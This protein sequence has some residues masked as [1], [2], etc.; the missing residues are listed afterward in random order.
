[1]ALDFT[2]QIIDLSED[3]PRIY[4][5]IPT[6]FD[7]S[8]KTTVED[9]IKN[10]K[11]PNRLT[12][13]LSVQ[14]VPDIDFSDIPNEKRILFLDKNIVYGIGKTRYHLQQLHNNEDYILSIDCHT[15]FQKDWD[16]SLIK[17][18]KEFNNDRA[19]IS[20]FLHDT[21]LDKAYVASEYKY[22]E[23]DA[24]AV[25][26][27]PVVPKKDKKMVVGHRKTQRVAPHFIFATK[28]FFDVSYP[29][30]YTWGHEDSLLSMKLFCNG[31]DIYELD[32]TFLTT[33]PKDLESCNNRRDW[34]LTGAKRFWD[35]DLRVSQESF[36]IGKN[37]SFDYNYDNLEYSYHL[38][39]N[40]TKKALELVVSF[41]NLLQY[42]FDDI[43]REDLRGL[44]R[45]MDEY[46][47][48]HGI[49]KDQISR[50]IANNL[51]RRGI[52]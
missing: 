17:R 22:G 47:E 23:Y 18:H 38:R 27:N 13:G 41:G 51:T 32:S 39:D 20:Q 12:F 7:P 35:R 10:A 15:G 37:S 52:I 49:T 8:I 46:F 3:Q 14:G 4:V 43:L 1:M 48:F 29:Y 5:M 26:Y 21:F 28:K 50:T 44:S 34:F 30:M 31:F 19:I 40:E 25:I 36:A 9:A 11:Y 33:V 45:T 42:G 6:L 2:K 16:E 24:L